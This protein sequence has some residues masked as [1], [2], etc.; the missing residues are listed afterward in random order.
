MAQTADELLSSI[1]DSVPEHTH[2]IADADPYFVINTETR[3]IENASLLPVV[4]MQYDHNSSVF[5][6]EIPRYVDG[7]DMMLCNKVRVHYNNISEDTGLENADVCDLND[8]HVDPSNPNNVLCTWTITRNATQLP[9]ILSFLVQYLCLDDTE[10]VYE[11]HSDFYEA[12]EIKT[13]RNN[14]EGSVIRYTDIL[15]QW[16]QR[17]FGAGE[18]VVAEIQAASETQKAEIEAKGA[19]TL[20]SI[21]EDYT[22]VANMADEALRRKA[23]AIILSESGEIIT[24]DDSSDCNLIDLNVYGKT[25]QVQTTGKNLLN[26][27]NDNVIAMDGYTD[28]TI[29]NGSVIISDLSFFMFKVPVEYGKMYTVSFNKIKTEETCHF[30]VYEY[31]AEPTAFTTNDANYVGNAVNQP[32]A[33]VSRLVQTYT[34][35]TS[36]VTWITVGFYTTRS[37]NITDF[38]VELG[39][40]ATSYE[41][42]SGGLLSPRPD[43]PQ[44][45]ISIENPMV[46]I[47]G[48][49]MLNPEA[50]VNANF[51][52]E[53]GVCTMTKTSDS[54][55]FSAFVPVYIPANTTFTIS[56]NVL[57]YTK[58]TSSVP[59]YVT[60][61]NG[62]SYYLSAKTSTTTSC[63][64][65]IKSIRF[66]LQSTEAT[67]AYIKFDNLQLE[68]GSEVT[69]YESYRPLQTIQINRTFRGIPVDKN[70]NY[71]DSKGQQWVCDEVDFKRGKYIQRIGIYEVSENT[72]VTA[73]VFS[74]GLP[75]YAIE[76]GRTLVRTDIK[77]Y[78]CNLLPYNYGVSYDHISNTPGEGLSRMWFRLTTTTLPNTTADGFRDWAMSNGLKVLYV[79]SNPVE[80]DL[81]AVELEAFRALK[82][83]ATN[84][85][86]LNDVKASMKLQYIADLERYIYKNV[87]NKKAKFDLTLVESE[88]VE[89]ADSR[90][91][92]QVLDINVRQNSAI[93]LHP[94]ADQQVSL[95][96]DGI[97]MFVAN[98]NGI[99]TAYSIGGTPGKN[100]TIPAT[101][102]VVVY[103]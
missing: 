37:N 95:I 10:P 63:T 61:I 18:S 59:M 26:V 23:D 56:F 48:K 15:E 99:V 22:E 20:A 74:E 19:E 94:T 27:S 9:G 73:E 44:D 67:G 8:L 53:N 46:R 11:W 76:E 91:Y 64:V 69:E 17:L 16:E 102:T 60:D 101:E 32:C 47:Y 90:Y 55:R 93:E 50:A 2:H 13:G 21:P 45:L 41:P 24:L 33:T 100:I 75:R 62:K 83:N 97:A 42:Y 92:T 70:S 82:S 57:E 66:Y 5:T 51:T 40:V 86:I 52:F 89:S 58:E 85:M 34:P 36:N 78:L 29:S 12:V 30:R 49:N 81:T 88:W 54:G 28:F 14:S 35:T 3:Q 6:F 7:H 38:M 71:I 4:L 80:T 68:L 103:E 79:M 84:T 96:L 43:Y 39:D 77:K 98:D 72:N 65:P 1:Q 25:T 31:S 87:S